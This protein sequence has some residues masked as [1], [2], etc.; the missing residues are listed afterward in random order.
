MLR[1]TVFRIFGRIL[2]FQ[3][4]SLHG[5]NEHLKFQNASKEAKKTKLRN[6]SW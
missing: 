1:S 4:R 6:M 2:K 5:V 3:M